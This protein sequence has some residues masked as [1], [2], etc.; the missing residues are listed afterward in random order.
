[1]NRRFTFGM[2][3]CL[4]VPSGG[5]S[6]GAR[7]APVS[8]SKAFDQ[9]GRVNSRVAGTGDAQDAGAGSDCFIRCVES[10]R[11]PAT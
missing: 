3:L 9:V 10:I 11:M 7:M 8:S 2:T 4:R 5:L 6:R 1:L